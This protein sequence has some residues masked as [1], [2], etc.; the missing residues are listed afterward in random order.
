MKL[1]G[2]LIAAVLVHAVSQGQVPA[3]PA[4]PAPVPGCTAAEHRQFDFWIGNWTVTVQS[5]PAGTNRIESSL[6]GCLL[7]ESWTGA[8]GGNGTSMNFYD[9]NTRAWHQTWVGEGGG[10]LQLRG[11]LVD[12]AMIMRSGALPVPAGGTVVHQITWSTQAE[13]RVRQ[14]WQSSSDEGKTWTTAF[15]GIYEKV[16]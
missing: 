9:R 5:K 2:L 16:K 13:G 4:Q 6:K 10:V 14:H 15:D 12:G 8:G 3:P 1:P 7:L 11:G